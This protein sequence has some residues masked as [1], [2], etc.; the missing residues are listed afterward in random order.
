MKKDNSNAGI[1]VAM[2]GARMGYAVPVMLHSAGR[3]KLFYSDYFSSRGV[4]R[5]LR[6]VPKPMRAGGVER[7]LCRDAGGLPPEKVVSFN[8]FG[9]EYVR[10]IRKASGGDLRG[11]YLWGG[12][13]FNRLVIRNMD[14][15]AGGVYAFNTAAR[16]LFVEARDR[17]VKTILEQ[18]IAPYE[19]EAQIVK[20]EQERF[21]GWE[22]ES[23]FP[24]SEAAYIRREKEEW[25]LADTILCGS[26][27]VQ[28]MIAKAGGDASKCRVVP[29]GVQMPEENPRPR[30]RHDGKL[31]VLFVGTLCLRK[32][33]QY[34]AQAAEKLQDKVEMV[35]VGP[36]LLADKGLKIVSES[37]KCVG[38]VPHVRMKEYWDWAD[39]LLLPSLCE[40]SATVTYEALSRGIPVI[41]T[42]ASGSLVE[43]GV[44]GFIVKTGSHCDIVAKLD[45]V[46]RSENSVAGLAAYA[47]ERKENVLMGAYALRIAELVK[48]GKL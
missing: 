3:L 22:Q 20:R 35:A 26:G 31:R 24:E 1:S 36:S 8:R 38:P 2:F 39:I 41:C 43:D 11:A 47:L 19:I 5:L 21:P 10:R 4:G 45:A 40:G 37:I 42:S 12:T 33:I 30:G 27:Y 6:L 13:E 23:L 9:L 48:N 34:A 15:D 44:S 25:S 28:D 16:D 46:S 29:Y 17:G 18:T 32:G 7:L 14:W